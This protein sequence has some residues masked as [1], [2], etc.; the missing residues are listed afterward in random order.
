MISA[1][2]WSLRAV[3]IAAALLTAV[4]PAAAQNEYIAGAEAYLESG[5]YPYRCDYPAGQLSTYTCD[6]P[7]ATGKLFASIDLTNTLH[8]S[9]EVQGKPNFADMYRAEARAY[10]F[11][12]IEFFDTPPA[13]LVFSVVLHG[14]VD[15]GGTN[16]RGI[17][18]GYGW[19]SE[20]EFGIVLGQTGAGYDRLRDTFHVPVVN[21]VAVWGLELLAQ[22]MI[23]PD[24]DGT[25]GQCSSALAD[26]SQT[27]YVENITG[28]DADG[29]TIT[30]GLR[31]KTASGV[32]YDLTGGVIISS[33]PEPA[34][35]A[36]MGT[37]LV[38]LLVTDRRRRRLA[39]LAA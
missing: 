23:Q 8:A 31:A 37:G 27:A 11:E 38:A 35:L 34:T 2:R 20:P 29:N 28:L 39:R 7:T 4:R 18:Y 22:A 17:L 19:H 24:P 15:G 21:G 3:S 36:L 9:A 1:Y 16:T 30:A 25:C 6:G 12:R 13:E 10:Y 32:S 5:T 14:R 33:A 26:F